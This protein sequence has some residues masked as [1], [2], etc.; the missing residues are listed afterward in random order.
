MEFREDSAEETKC[1]ET[2]KDLHSFI[3]RH[4]LSEGAG[5]MAGGAGEKVEARRE[6]IVNFDR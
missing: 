6:I 3:R 4:D 5:T 2:A 1:G